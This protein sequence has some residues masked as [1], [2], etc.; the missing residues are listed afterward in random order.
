[1]SDNK[2]N[3]IGPEAG[4]TY[5]EFYFLLRLLKMK[6][7]ETVSFE[8]IDDIGVETDNIQTFYQL[9]HTVA[10][11]ETKIVNLTPRDADLWKTLHLWVC[12]TQDRE[13][14]VEKRT[15]EEQ[16]R[17]LEKTQ[18]VLVTNK[19]E[20]ENIFCGCVRSI[21]NNEI[22]LDEFKETFKKLKDDTKGADIKE[23]MRDVDN[24]KP[25][26]EF[27][28]RITFECRTD[29]DIL[30]DIAEELINYH[31]VSRE[32]SVDV[33]R[34][35]LGTIKMEF[36]HTI[37]KNIPL[38]YTREEFT[39]KFGPYITGYSKRKFVPSSRFT[40]FELPKDPWNQTFVKQLIDIKDLKFNKDIDDLN[41]YTQSKLRFQ[42][43]YFQMIN[44]SGRSFGVQLEREA[45]GYWRNAFKNETPAPED[46]PSEKDIV[47]A[48]KKV[49]AN[50]REKKLKVD[51]DEDSLDI[52]YSNGCYYYFS[53][54]PSPRIGWRMDWMEK[55]N[56]EQWITD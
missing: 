39:N 16:K 27:L 14:D 52:N 2:Y 4:F 26:D 23:Y 8:K 3:G 20:K 51:G 12:L 15:L 22:T 7:E 46:N 40:H 29:E 34:F 21:Q 56:G 44:V 1:M 17:W 9:K 25:L 47:T 41:E 35:L 30:H 36:A 54:G 53:D 49:L 43:D 19:G 10:T 28:R 50:V 24:L 6:V 42:N 13:E 5:Q 45:K 48:A 32:K 38:S 18:F 37:Q 31:Y 55:Y 33:T 11:T